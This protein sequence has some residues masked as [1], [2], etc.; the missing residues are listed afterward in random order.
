MT[1]AAGGFQILTRPVVFTEKVP[2][3]GD[4]GDILLSAFSQYAIGLRQEVVLDQSHLPGWARDVISYRA[5]L[6]VD[7]LGLWS[8]P[9][10]PLHGD[11]LSWCVALAA[12]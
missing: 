8:G 1:Q 11:T 6:R 7:G 4:R 10:T 3:L 12:R 2:V 9:V 5:I